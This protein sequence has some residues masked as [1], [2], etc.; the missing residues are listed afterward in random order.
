MPP[1]DPASA[2]ESSAPENQSPLDIAQIFRD[3]AAQAQGNGPPASDVSVTTKKLVMSVFLDADE[4]YSVS[5]YNERAGQCF[6]KIY[7]GLDKGPEYDRQAT[8]VNA[9]IQAITAPNA[10]SLALQETRKAIAANRNAN[11][12]AV[13]V[14]ALAAVCKPWFDL[15]DGADV[16]EGAVR[17]DLPATAPAQC[18]GDYTLPSGYIFFPAPFLK[19]FG[20][21]YGQLLKRQV[22]H[23]IAGLRATNTPPS[24]SISRVIFAA[25]P[26]DDD[27]IARTLIGVMM[28]MLPTASINLTNTMAAWRTN[29]GAAFTALQTALKQST[30]TDPYLRARGVLL[31]PLM[32]AMQANPMPPQVWRTATRDHTIGTNPPAQVKRGEKVIVDI[33][34]ATREDLSANITDVFPVFGGDRSTAPHGTH[35]CPGYQAATGVMLGVLNGVMEPT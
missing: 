32:Q 2:R 7:L 15:P 21:A 18:P 6:G 4:N 34:S 5:G 11:D 23:F 22:D 33:A 20:E 1:T 17:L 8:K 24:G 30:E 26:N 19:D 3:L 12:D 28:G 25:F 35:A 27:L 29:N 14:A 31:L 13:T 16:K 9:A 10:F